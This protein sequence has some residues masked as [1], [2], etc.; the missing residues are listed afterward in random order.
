VKC[1]IRS[2][3][4]EIRNEFRH[5]TSDIRNQIPL[6]PFVND[7]YSIEE[8]EIKGERPALPTSNFQLPKN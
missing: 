5:H 7:L 8:L 4:S 1:E 3:K 6:A 2:L